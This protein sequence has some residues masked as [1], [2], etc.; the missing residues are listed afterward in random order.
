MPVYL[1]NTQRPFLLKPILLS[2]F[3]VSALLTTASV[4]ADLTSEPIASEPVA[5][6]SVTS[7][8]ASEHSHTTPAEQARL[9]NKLYRQALYYYFEG[10][11]S[12][13][14]RQVSLNR[15]RFGGDTAKS[16][17]FEA[18]LQVSIGLHHQATQ[19]LARF[20]QAL[21]QQ[22]TKDKLAGIEQAD[23]DKQS[24]STTSPAELKLIALLQLSEQQIEQGKQSAAQQTLSKI[25]QLPASYAEQY[26]ILNQLAYWPAFVSP[27]AKVIDDLAGDF[28]DNFSEKTSTTADNTGADVSSLSAYV[29]LNQALQMIESEDY[30][31]AEALLKRIKQIRLSTNETN[32]WQDLFTEKIP[33]SLNSNQPAAKEPSA[34]ENTNI[35]A[36]KRALTDKQLQ[37][38]AIND[39]AQLLL[40]QMYVKQ[41]RY[42]GAFDQ[43]K[44]FPQ[45][46]PYSESALFLFAF[47]AQQVKQ[48]TTSLGLLDL[49]KRQYPH[50]QLG[51]QSAL[52]M[53]AQI[54]EQNTL[55][56]SFSSYQQAEQLY[57]KQLADLARF[58]TSIKQ[59]QLN[60]LLKASNT[61]R[62]DDNNHWLQKALQD[63]ALKND[64]DTLTE[65]NQLNEN[66]AKQQQKNEWIKTML[67]LNERRKS[68]IVEQ[69]QSTPYAELI[70]QLTNKKQELALAITEAETQQSADIF[71][72]TSEQDWLDRINKS[73]Q[74]INAIKNQRNTED[75]QQRLAR[76]EAV[77]NWQ[78]QQTFPERLWQHKKL[79]KQVDQ[80]LVLATQQHQRFALLA[81][82]QQAN[83]FELRQSKAELA[84][85][86]VTTN[87]TAL[88]TATEQKIQ[89]KIAVFV[90][91]QRA[92]L[93]QLLLTSR[94]EMAAVLEQ[95]SQPEAPINQ[96]T[97]VSDSTANN[98]PANNNAVLI[99]NRE[100]L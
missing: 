94:H 92:Q 42:Q 45:H 81:E 34:S 9:R 56:E 69:Q 21:I 38:Q 7:N 84:L 89:Q 100:G 73:Q 98:S 88:K 2:L 47:S 54:K 30:Q 50:S 93:E 68:R 24:Q 63:A 64:V 76:V 5:S 83:D 78:L 48:Y 16:H 60:D 43:L 95:M 18:G 37:Q 87:I 23:S 1:N 59:I 27:S 71:A 91:Q 58:Q 36:N 17:L 82:S 80:Q 12:A 13:A 44:D 28:S 86:A 96:P 53:A 31:S 51:W 26:H 32:F 20:E 22:Q 52:L 25:T 66:I 4:N 19:T 70:Q 8:S 67:N 29:M 39:Y 99:N 6:K 90:S 72:N 79:L 74:I 14:L 10:D 41:E 46:S 57:L 33:Q 85:K 62:D 35:T 3:T 97:S 61:S 75:Y 15:Q 55:P 49:I 11:Y 65:L 40:A 77:L